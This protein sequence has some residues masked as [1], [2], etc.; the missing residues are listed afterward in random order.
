MSRWR[1]LV[2]FFL[3]IAPFLALAVLG[4]YYLWRA[5]L[6]LWVWWPLF[7]LTALG[8]FL[9]WYW[10]RRRTLLR[11]VDFTPP[12]EWT[13]RD[14]EAWRLVEERARKA[15]EVDPGRLVEINFYVDTARD[16]ALELARVYYPRAEDFYSSV[17]VPELLAAVEHAAHDVAEV[18][19]Q[20][21]PGGHL[22]TLRNWRQVRKAVDWYPTLNRAYWLVSALIWPMST[23]Q[24]Y[25]ASQ[26]GVSLPF[27]AIQENALAFL[28]TAF[29]HRVGTYLIDLNSGRLRVGATRYR[30]L[31]EGKLGEPE[32]QAA[33]AAERVQQLTITVAGQ[34]KAGKSSLINALLGE[35]RART[36]VV[37]RTAE[38]TAYELKLPD[39]PTRLA[40]LDTVGYNQAGPRADQL[41]AT[42]EAARQSDLVLL[43]LHARNPARQADVEL[44]HDLERWFAE[45]PDLKRPPI[46]GVLT[47]IDL[48]SPSLEW[49]PP[50][51]WRQPKRPK[52]EQIAQAVAAAR[53]QLGK[54]VADVVPVCTAAGKVLGVEEWLLP[55]LVQALDEARAVAL[56]RCIRAES[57]TGRAWKTVQQLIAVSLEAGRVLLEQYGKR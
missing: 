15:P 9:A 8:Y 30:E 54:L 14:R 4:S 24:R 34:V 48:L 33:A 13:D 56:V 39:V 22:L 7:G 38:I 55:A 44:L 31:K 17:T 10:Q 36:D 5:G 19:D 51:D 1:I 49:S 45:H 35:Q 53:E 46:I 32:E 52:E 18:V 23:V 25:L 20:Y 26:V 42:R 6:M 16:M 40:L 21:L 2:V 29:V 3:V 27:K 12:V 50:Y 37:P 43:A 11:P 57:N 28:Y 47:H 41:K